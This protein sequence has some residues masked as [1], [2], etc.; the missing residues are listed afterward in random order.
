[1]DLSDIPEEHRARSG[2]GGQTHFPVPGSKRNLLVVTG[3]H[4]FQRDPFYEI[5]ESNTQ[6][7]WSAVE[8]PAAQLLFTPEI[9][10]HF[11]CYVLYDMPGIQFVRDGDRKPIFHAPPDFYQQGLLAMLEQGV[12]LVVL[13]HAIA[14]WPAWPLGE[15]ILGGRFHYQPYSDGDALRPDSGY[16]LNVTH[17]ITPVSGHPIVEGLAP[18]DLTDELYLFHVHAGDVEPLLVSDFRFQQDQFFSARRALEGH[19]NDRQGWDHPSGTALIGW[20]KHYGNSPIV[21]LQCG[22]GP[23][24]YGDPQFRR[25]LYN[26]IDWA[27]SPQAREWVRKRRGKMNGTALENVT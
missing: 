9:A 24:T 3:G 13:H 14:A 22:D 7:E 6:I 26:A 5:F 1:M 16:R 4:A 19:M 10:R 27:C 11:D 18:F 12:P 15:D 8:H 2:R 20:V 21:Y 25:L 17:R 23:L